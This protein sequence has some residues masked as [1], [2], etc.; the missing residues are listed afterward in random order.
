M[1]DSKETSLVNQVFNVIEQ[2][3]F[4]D[5]L[6]QGKSIDCTQLAKDL[7]VG[8][9]T[10]NQVIPL[11][12]NEMLVEEIEKEFYVIGIS[13][14]DVED[15]YKIKRTVEVDA[16]KL[17]CMNLS[18]E[19]LD[20]LKGIIEKQKMNLE[21]GK[22]DIVTGLDTMFHDVVLTGCGSMVYR[23]V[24]SPIHHRLAKYRAASLGNN[25]RAQKSINEHLSIYEAFL[26]RDV[27]RVEKLVKEHIENAYNSIITTNE[28]K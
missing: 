21:E 11:L 28:R 26:A 3:I 18:D 14:K 1:L 9:S 8:V 17:A 16:F 20:V 10:V 4:T 13:A 15:M 5:K 23:W 2:M 12:I 27:E 25:H 24:L 7:N 22:E 19:K 6:P